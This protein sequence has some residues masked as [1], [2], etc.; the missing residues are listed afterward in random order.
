[1]T[2]F[3]GIKIPDKEIQAVELQKILTKFNCVIKLR[4]GIN[5]SIFCSK[6][7]IIILQIDS[8]N[9]AIL[10]EKELIEI[11]EIELQKMIF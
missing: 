11:S 7:G 2:I 5:S 9:D 8:N 4:I 6:T 1:M 3:I 10:L